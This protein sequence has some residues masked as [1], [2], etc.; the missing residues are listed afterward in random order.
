[1]NPGS[2]NL[3]LPGLFYLTSLRGL[4]DKNQ[5]RGAEIAVRAEFPIAGGSAMILMN[6]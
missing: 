6:N 5:P 2:P 1:M 3:D 4:L